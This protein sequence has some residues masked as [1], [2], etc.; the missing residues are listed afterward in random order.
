MMMAAAK[1]RA[2]PMRRPHIVG[3]AMIAITRSSIEPER[4]ELGLCEPMSHSP[5]TLMATTAAPM[6]SQMRAIIVQPDPKVYPNII[7]PYPRIIPYPLIIPKPK[8]A[9]TPIRTSPI[10]WKTTPTSARM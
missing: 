5:Y 8:V 6:V 4:M 9:I 2:D 7:G 10:A 3:K 1:I